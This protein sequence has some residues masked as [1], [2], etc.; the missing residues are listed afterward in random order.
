[1]SFALSWILRN[2]KISNLQCHW[3]ESIAQ[4]WNAH[5]SPEGLCSPVPGFSYGSPQEAQEDLG[6]LAS[7][8]VS[9][10]Q[11]T[12]EKHSDTGSHHMLF[13]MSYQYCYICS[14]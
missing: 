12:N 2:T 10:S 13:W 5:G 11:S 7:S 3:L 4:M 14:D 8:P 9:C 6:T 1:M